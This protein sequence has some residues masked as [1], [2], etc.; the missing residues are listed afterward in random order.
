MADSSVLGTMA[1]KEPS[2]GQHA[3][4]LT[5]GDHAGGD[6]PVERAGVTD[7]EKVERVYR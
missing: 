2:V 3:P 1:E 5:L 7:I 6:L 4:R